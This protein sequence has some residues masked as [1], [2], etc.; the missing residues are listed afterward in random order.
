MDMAESERNRLLLAALTD[1]FEKVGMR[2]RFE[3]FGIDEVRGRGGR[4]R[5]REKEMIIVNSS[6]S[7]EEKIDVLAQELGKMQLDDIYLPPNIRDLIEK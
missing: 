5:I 3:D 1:V 7:I 4:C 2:V 6:I